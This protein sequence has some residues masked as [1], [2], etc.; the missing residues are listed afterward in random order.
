MGSS[1]KKEVANLEIS[2]IGSGN[3]Q[4]L[5]RQGKGQIG[6][7]S[8]LW[9]LVWLRF[10]I[11]GRLIVLPVGFSQEEFQVSLF[12]PAQSRMRFARC[13]RRWDY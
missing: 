12:A 13:E 11:T 10:A 5:V 9:V 3:M 8:I 2:D 6:H 4:I 7:Y 1:V